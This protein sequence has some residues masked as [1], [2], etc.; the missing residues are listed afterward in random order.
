MHIHILGICGTFMGGIA[1]LAREMGV[2][3]SGSDSNP[4]PPMSTQLEKL[5][6]SI[7]RYDAGNLDPQ[8]DIVVIGNA[9]SR[10]NPEVEAVLEQDLNYISGPQWLAEHATTLPGRG[11][12]GSCCFGVAAED[13]S[14]SGLDPLRPQGAGPELGGDRAG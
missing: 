13:P 2:T 4:Y 8:P 10:G 7:N 12:H 1:V 11:P 9:L 6:I 3:V 5:G 14:P